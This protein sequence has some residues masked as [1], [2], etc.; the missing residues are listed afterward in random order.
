LATVRRLTGRTVRQVVT[1]P[2]L[3]GVKEIAERIE[4]E[5]ETLRRETGAERVDVV[6]HSMGGLAGR[7]FMLKLGGNRFIRR[8]V[9]IAT[10][11]H[12]TQWAHLGFTQSLKD[13]V[14]GNPLLKELSPEIPVPGVKC[15]NIRAGWDQ[16]VWPREHGRWGE[17]AKEHELPF[18]E[19][20]AVQADV[21]L[22]A[23]VLTELE[24]SDEEA[25]EG[26]IDM[27]GEAAAQELGNAG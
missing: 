26:T 23:L 16:I 21:R 11:H 20:W 22:L 13:M 8:F 18:A 3:G 25:L 1:F 27:E 17:H 14:P 10:P 4:R 12:G 2:A 7:Y 24:A 9:S 19:H 15:L 5:V 6:T